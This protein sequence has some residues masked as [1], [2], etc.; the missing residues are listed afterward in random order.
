MQIYSNFPILF[1]SLFWI[2]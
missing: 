2:I 1:K